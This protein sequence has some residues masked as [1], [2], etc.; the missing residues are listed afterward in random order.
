MKRNDIHDFQYYGGCML[1]IVFIGHILTNQHQNPNRCNHY[2]INLFAYLYLLVLYSKTTTDPA[3]IANVTALAF[4]Y[5]HLF[6][7]TNGG[8]VLVFE[9]VPS[10]SKGKVKGCG[11]ELRFAAAEGLQLSCIVDILCQPMTSLRHTSGLSFSDSPSEQSVEVLVLGQCPDSSSS[12]Y[13]TFSLLRRLKFIPKPTSL[14]RSSSQSST[15]S[16][17]RRGSPSS[18]FLPRKALSSNDGC[19][20]SLDFP[21]PIQSVKLTLSTVSPTATTFLPLKH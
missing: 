17:S 13:Y 14:R 10:K 8:H 5:P 7:G 18:I 15:P 20:S 19:S 4:Q 3:S 2:T 1:I 6:I 21:S 16:N 12:D 9:L 11:K